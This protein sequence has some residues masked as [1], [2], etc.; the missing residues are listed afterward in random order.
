MPVKTHIG[1]ISS[2]IEAGKRAA[3]SIDYGPIQTLDVIHSDQIRF[4]S[5]WQNDSMDPTIF[6]FGVHKWALPS[7][8][9]TK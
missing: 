5:D 6:I 9:V 3:A 1:Q 4:I 2:A 7:L 8:K